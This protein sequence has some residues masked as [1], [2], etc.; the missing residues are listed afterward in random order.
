MLLPSANFRFWCTWKVQQTL[1]THLIATTSKLHSLRFRT[2]AIYGT[3]LE[4]VTFFNSS[5][6]Q[7][8]NPKGLAGR[9][10]PLDP[11]VSFVLFSLHLP[12]ISSAPPLSFSGRMS[13]E[14][15]TFTLVEDGDTHEWQTGPLHISDGNH[16]MNYLITEIEG[17][18]GFLSWAKD[19]R[20][21][22]VTF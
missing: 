3:P 22:R 2:F 8:R 6:L 12:W 7:F 1:E 18:K 14:A 15:V 9:T 4:V 16:S 11:H 21:R 10:P 5:R 20:N 17:P 13:Q 19:I